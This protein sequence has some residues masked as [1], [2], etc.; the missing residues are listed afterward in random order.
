MEK[1]RVRALNDFLMFHHGSG[2]FFYIG[3]SL[4]VRYVKKKLQDG[5]LS[6]RLLMVR[7]VAK[8]MWYIPEMSEG[9]TLSTDK[10]SWDFRHHD[11]LPHPSPTHGDFIQK[12]AGYFSHVGSDFT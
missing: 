6:H 5:D 10:H 11:N 7:Q 4:Y 3:G 8:K 2:S 12:R 1:L 9:M